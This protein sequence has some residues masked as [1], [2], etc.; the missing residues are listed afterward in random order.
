MKNRKERMKDKTGFRSGRQPKANKN[1]H[2]RVVAV[3]PA[4]L[5]SATDDTSSNNKHKIYIKCV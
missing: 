1:F 4:P 5:F 3:A 2:H